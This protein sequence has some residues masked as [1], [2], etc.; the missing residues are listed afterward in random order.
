MPELVHETPSESEL[1][2]YL[3]EHVASSML[4]PF[5]MTR[6]QLS[7]SFAPE[8]ARAFVSL[9]ELDGQSFARRAVDAIAVGLAM[10][11]GLAR[12][13]VFWRGTNS[14]PTIYKLGEFCRMKRI[15]DPRNL[16]L[17]W[18]AAILPVWFGSNDFGQEAWVEFSRLPEFEVRWPLYAALTIHLTAN[19]T[20]DQ[21]SNF[22]R[23]VNAIRESGPIL[24]R[25]ATEG[26]GLAVTW[27]TQILQLIGESIQA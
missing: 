25:I 2:A 10:M 6:E 14:R 16:A 19:A 5:G 26:D 13:D 15:E 22:L 8:V 23:E 1:K 24:R 27:A 3:E 4:A 18:V 17:L 12:T 7:Q 20:E 21:V 11:N 9:R